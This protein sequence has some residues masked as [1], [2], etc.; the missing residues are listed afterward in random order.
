MIYWID[1][2]YSF[3]LINR[4]F[5]NMACGTAKHRLITVIILENAP[6]NQ[7]WDTKSS[8]FYPLFEEDSAG[9]HGVLIRTT[10]TYLT[11]NWS[12][13]TSSGKERGPSRDETPD[14]SSKC[15]PCR[16]GCAYCRDDT[17]CLVQE[18]GAL[19]LAVASFQGL[20]MVL[21]LA[22]MVVVYHFRRNKV[23][24][25]TEA[26]GRCFISVYWSWSHYY[27]AVIPQSCWS[28][29][30]LYSSSSLWP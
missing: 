1:H 3:K 23:R 19:R 21:D 7:T 5:N 9:T 11:V 14:V 28:D 13:L 29:G 8:F 25:D 18:D 22:G 10:C 30:N 17:P 6:A 15:L 20:C 27:T 26:H 12:A 24:G 4:A 16:E 2:F